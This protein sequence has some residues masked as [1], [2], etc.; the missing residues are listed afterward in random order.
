MAHLLHLSPRDVELLT[1]EEFESAIAWIDDY[2]AQ[3][4]KG[5]G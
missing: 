4:E 5:G 2:R 1:V 3:A